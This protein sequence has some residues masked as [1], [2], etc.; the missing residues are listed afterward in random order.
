MPRVF[1]NRSVQIQP[2]SW[3][4]IVKV[5]F[6]Q[7]LSVVCCIAL[8]AGCGSTMVDHSS[9]KPGF[10]LTTSSSLDHSLPIEP[11]GIP[12]VD[13]PSC[14]PFASVQTQ[15]AVTTV[16]SGDAESLIRTV[17]TAEPGMTILLEDGVYTL[18]HR[19]YLALNSPYLTIRGASGNRE[20]VRIEG[21]STTFI[22]N[23]DHVTIA[24][25]TMSGPAFHHIQVRGE[26]GVSG[27]RI[28]NV[29]LL[30]AGQQFVKVSAGNGT[31]QQFGD[32]GLVACSVMEYTTF[33]KGNGRTSPTYTNGVDILA[34]KG[35]VIRDNVFRRIRSEKGPAGPA[36][37]VWRNAMD[38]VIKRNVIVDSWRG[39]ALGLAS[40]GTH[41]RGG[42]GVTYD[43]QNGLVENNVI[44][45]L[46]ESADAAIENNYARNSRILHNT[47][48]YRKDLP[49]AVN[50]SIEY[51][52][53]PTSATIQNNLSNLPIRQR[54]PLA[55]GEAMIQGNVT[56]AR[57]DWF[58]NVSTED[59][60]LSAGTYA[61]DRG[62][63][64]SGSHWDFE[65]VLRP[66]GQA[67]DVGADEFEGSVTKSK[68]SK[69]MH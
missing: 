21:G 64:L 52:F 18:S 36:I 16:T 41:S 23:A 40:P 51:R 4:E 7:V 48:Y 32:D 37:L 5:I 44:L 8:A 60:H 35:W 15:D 58:R 29:H 26:R 31:G 46:H 14:P 61:I 1:L 13:S 53:A 11:F 10:A 20:H 33:S 24:D 42:A 45:A 27:T 19:Q 62:V 47:I 55:R 54:F 34:G 67:P 65:G 66:I 59:V 28:Y 50:W 56:N 25:L 38:T 68:L 43:H 22:V 9:P 30:D 69:G 6:S 39:I 49:H 2:K 3:R 12:I 17:K 63:G 57:A